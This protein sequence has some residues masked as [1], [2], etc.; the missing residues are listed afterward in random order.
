MV[1]NYRFII[2]AFVAIMLLALI[3][4]S[5]SVKS[6]SDIVRVVSPTASRPDVPQDFSALPIDDE[7]G[8]IVDDK[9][10]N[11]NPSVASAVKEHSSGT[12]SDAK[13]TSSASAEY[14]TSKKCDKD[15]QFVL[16]IDAGSSGSRIHV[17][18]FDVCTQPPTLI[19]ETFKM[20]EP[21]L[22]SYDTDAEGAAR[23]LDP[24]LE[25]ALETIP[26]DKRGL[27]TRGC[28]GHCW[29]EITGD[30]K[31]DKILS[32]VRSHLENDYPFPCG[33]RRW[34]FWDGR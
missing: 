23:S 8:Y 22:S 30:A 25:R 15:H 1:R 10:D 19:E 33:A 17:Y 20:L 13:S 21:G 16:M 28:E 18:E 4:S 26:K 5:T 11:G 7:P 29:F 27:C 12:I 2:F 34:C 14:S 3:K 32:A 6:A 31:A 24:L 9:T